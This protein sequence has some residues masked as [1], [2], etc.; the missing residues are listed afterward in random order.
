MCSELSLLIAKRITQKTRLSEENFFSR[1][2]YTKRTHSGTKPM[3]VK[4][5]TQLFIAEANQWLHEIFTICLIINCQVKK[6]LLL[7]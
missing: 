1:M 5:L 3:S 4:I 7:S 6:K 2:G